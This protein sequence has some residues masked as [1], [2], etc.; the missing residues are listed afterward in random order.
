M[1][2]RALICSL[3][4]GS[5]L[6]GCNAVDSMKEGFEHSNA[7]AADLEK[8]LGSKPFVGFNWA[9]GVLVNVNVEFGVRPAGKSLD[10]IEA[11]TRDAVKKEF[12]Q[13]PRKIVLA[14]D[15]DAK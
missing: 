1:A 14:F 3:L 2:F 4:L 7:V 6:G 8:S 11:A 5:A 10:E 15:M 9:N 13:A 12:A